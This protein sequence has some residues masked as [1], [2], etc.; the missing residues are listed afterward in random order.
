MSFTR[1]HDDP[2]RI[3]KQLAESTFLGRYQLDTPGQG[4]DLPF[5]EDP[6]LRLQKWG[7]NL[8]TN[9]VNLESD[10]LGMTRRVNRD[11]I[12]ENNHLTYA[13]PAERRNFRN[14]DPFI[15]ESRASQPAWTYRDLEQTRWETPFLNPQAN[16][17]KK[18]HDNIQTRILEKDSY[19][20]PTVNISNNSGFLE[21]Y[22]MK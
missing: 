21:F 3:Q 20:Q 9:G 6:H 10:L 16:L 22:S 18:F 8:R 14:A 1:F 17:E 19:V 7:A 11:F 5:M 2:A 15:E 13:V 12:D 4:V